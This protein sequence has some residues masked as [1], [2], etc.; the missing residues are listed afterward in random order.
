MFLYN[1]TLLS[2][3]ATYPPKITSV[4]SESNATAVSHN[5]AVYITAEAVTKV[6]GSTL[7]VSNQNPALSFTSFAKGQWDDQATVQRVYKNQ[8][9]F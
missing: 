2:V 8:N 3:G 4:I 5:I 9:R 7:N 1:E 6:S